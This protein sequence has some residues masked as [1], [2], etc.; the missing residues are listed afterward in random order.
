MKTETITGADLIKVDA[1][2]KRPVKAK[3]FREP[4]ASPITGLLHWRRS[5]DLKFAKLRA[6]LIPKTSAQPADLIELAGGNGFEELSGPVV[7]VLRRLSRRTKIH[8]GNRARNVPVDRI[9]SWVWQPV[10][11]ARNCEL[12]ATGSKPPPID[13]VEVRLGRQKFFFIL[14]GHHRTEVCK[15]RQEPKILAKVKQVLIFEARKWKISRSGAR[16]VVGHYV[17]LGPDEVAAAR[18]LGVGG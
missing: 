12:S 2:L 1:W 6:R 3:L 10:R 13:A 9:L 8:P 17:K 7:Q 11:V 16:D 5:P 15:M 14:D 18:W 4:K